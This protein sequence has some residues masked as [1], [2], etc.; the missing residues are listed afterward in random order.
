MFSCKEIADGFLPS[1]LSLRISKQFEH[2]KAGEDFEIT[3]NVV[4]VGTR[5]WPKEDFILRLYYKPRRI[6]GIAAS[7]AYSYQEIEGASFRKITEWQE[8]IQPSPET[9]ND[10]YSPSIERE[11]V[12]T[13]PQQPQDAY[14]FRFTVERI[15]SKRPLMTEVIVSVLGGGII[16]TF[17]GR[18]KVKKEQNRLKEEALE[19]EKGGS[20]KIIDY[21]QDP[22]TNK[23]KVEIKNTGNVAVTIAKIK[24]Y[25]DGEGATMPEGK[26]EP[27]KTSVYELWWLEPEEVT[28]VKKIRVEGLNPDIYDEI[29]P[30]W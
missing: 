20:I 3:L 14:Q 17:E 6:G 22:S 28:K 27:G 8:D 9:Q 18:E 10:F 2:P 11:Y 24:V 5:T 16:T 29:K 1:D 13:L 4:N 21:F 12:W 7:G 15:V 23:L 19:E 25:H 26:L 30:E